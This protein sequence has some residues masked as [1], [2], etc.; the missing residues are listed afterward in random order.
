MK[1]L[2]LL[3]WKVQLQRHCASDVCA[4]WAMYRKCLLYINLR[5]GTVSSFDKC[6][7]FCFLRLLLSGNVQHFLNPWAIKEICI[8]GLKQSFEKRS[9]PDKHQTVTLRPWKENKIRTERIQ[10]LEQKCVRNCLCG[11][12]PLR[13]P[14]SPQKLHTKAISLEMWLYNTFGPDLVTD[15]AIFV[16]AKWRPTVLERFNHW[17]KLDFLRNSILFS[18]L[19]VSNT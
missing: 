5:S 9:P 11:A 7:L 8:Y 3:L 16:P 12:Q 4:T 6:S 17:C 2:S 1:L 14:F 19:L 18:C 13:F 10:Q 15:C